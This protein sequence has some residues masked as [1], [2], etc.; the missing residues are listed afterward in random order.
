[1]TEA[2]SI[3]E[4]GDRGGRRSGI[5]RRK[6]FIPGY[7][8]ERRSGLDRRSGQERAEKNP[9]KV[10]NLSSPLSGL[11]GSV[12]GGIEFFLYFSFLHVASQFN[13]TTDNH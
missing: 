12:K 6:I 5:E 3:P 7:T 11:P 9:E 13:I 8:P 10:L 1:V 2:D 4:K